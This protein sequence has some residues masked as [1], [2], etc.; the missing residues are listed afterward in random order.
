MLGGDDTSRD[1][2]ET[3]LL[4][5]GLE[6]DAEGGPLGE[7]RV[8]AR[9]FSAANGTQW[10]LTARNNG[11]LQWEYTGEFSGDVDVSD[12]YEV[13]VYNYRDFDCYIEDFGENLADKS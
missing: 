12:V 2:V 5:N 6:A 8:W 10:T 7:Y 1:G 11:L 13:P 9:R 4:L 3:F